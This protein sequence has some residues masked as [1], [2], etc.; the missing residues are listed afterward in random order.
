MMQRWFAAAAAGLFAA[1]AAAHAQCA[2]AGPPNPPAT[3]RA[4]TGIVM[5]TANQVLENVNV[6]I[7]KPRRQAKT[8]ARGRF[9]LTD[10][11]TGVY[12]IRVFRIGYEGAA[13][14]YVVTDSGGVARFC[15]MP[16]PSRLPPIVTS[17]RRLGLSGV[18]GDSAYKAVEGAE[19]RVIGSG[20]HALT[21]T[22]G[23]FHL[24]V[25]RGTYPVWIAKPGYLRQLVSV[26]IPP[27][28]GREIAVWL[29]EARG[30]NASAARIDEMRTRILWARPNRSTLI[31][32]EQIA[33]S[34]ASL[35]GLVG[36][37]ARAAINETCVALIDGGIGKL[38]L[39]MIDKESVQMVEV[40]LQGTPRNGPSL[41]PAGT[42]GG[43]TITAGTQ[44]SGPP[45]GNQCGS[46]WVWLKR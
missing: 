20:L 4:I 28:S 5:D 42:A 15:L 40:Y 23:V 22:A 39:Y 41:D 30:A 12:E 37:K 35:T 34:S 17:A 18:V 29:R 32:A 27:D 38:P 11:D 44:S 13:K 9:T 14:D 8:D 25:S 31:S 43:K 24:P 6:G 26:T 33:S 46:I 1:G 45:S 19:V 7:M 2:P 16:E 36:V 3:K 10:L 21:D